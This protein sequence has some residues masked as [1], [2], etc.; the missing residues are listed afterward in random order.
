MEIKGKV[1]KVLFGS[2]H[3]IALTEDGQLFSMG[4]SDKGC[5]GN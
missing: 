2:S 3:I 4:K 5:L 1:S